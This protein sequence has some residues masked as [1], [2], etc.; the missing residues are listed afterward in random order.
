MGN[1]FSWTDSAA[2]V[3]VC[4]CRIT[5]W[6]IDNSINNWFRIKIRYTFEQNEQTEKPLN[7]F[8]S[9]CTYRRKKVD[10]KEWSSA[11]DFSY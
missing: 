10:R 5:L 9:W 11:C 1:W 8:I 6:L 2:I 3:Y 7:S 4:V